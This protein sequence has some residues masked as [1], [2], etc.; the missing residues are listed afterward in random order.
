VVYFCKVLIDRGKILKEYIKNLNPKVTVADLARKLEYDRTTIYQH[1]NNDKLDYSI[2][3]KYGKVL[4]HDFSVEFPEMLDYVSTVS[5]PLAAYQTMTVA[6]ALIERDYWKDKYI[7]LMEKHHE[8]L[9]NTL[10]SKQ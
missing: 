3:F 2:I 6:E 1:F 5:E 9:T 4:R 8:L 7:S 10:N